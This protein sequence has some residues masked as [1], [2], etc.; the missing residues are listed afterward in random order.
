MTIWYLET[1]E[2]LT[3]RTAL[4]MVGHDGSLSLSLSLFL[5]SAPAHLPAFQPFFLLAICSQNAMLKN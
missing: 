3:L 2:N 1:I 5:F 4:K